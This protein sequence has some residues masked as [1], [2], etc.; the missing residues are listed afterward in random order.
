MGNLLVCA[1]GKVNVNIYSI[2]I[3]PIHK[4]VH[5]RKK[6]SIKQAEILLVNYK[7]KRPERW[8]VLVDC[9]MLGSILC[10]LDVDHMKEAVFCI[11]YSVSRSG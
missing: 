2:R 11:S 6:T 4:N 7:K 9:V 5:R 10:I 3:R 8:V 1:R